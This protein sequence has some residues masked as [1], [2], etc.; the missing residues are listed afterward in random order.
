MKLSEFASIIDKPQTVLGKLTILSSGGLDISLE[1][2][3]VTIIYE[4]S[5]TPS[6]TLIMSTTASIFFSSISTTPTQTVSNIITT[7]LKP[8]TAYVI[9][10][11]GTLLTGVLCSYALV[12]CFCCGR[13]CRKKKRHNLNENNGRVLESSGHYVIRRPYNLPAFRANYGNMPNNFGNRVRADSQRRPPPLPPLATCPFP[14]VPNEIH[15]NKHKDDDDDNE[16]E[17]EVLI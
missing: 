17:N 11:S 5:P 7:L 2:S 15:F 16:V 8:T 3:Q 10:I 14:L 1:Y 12:A 6:S 9:G 13:H 4:I